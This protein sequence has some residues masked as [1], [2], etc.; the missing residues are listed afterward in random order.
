MSRSLFLL[1]VYLDRLESFPFP[2]WPSSWPTYDVVFTD[3]QHCIRR[4]M[5]WLGRTALS[6]HSRLLL[7]SYSQFSPHRLA[8]CCSDPQSDHWI[9]CTPKTTIASCNPKRWE[10][11][12]LRVTE[13]TPPDYIA[14]LFRW[15]IKCLQ[16]RNFKMLLF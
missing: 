13:E 7:T 9:G 4:Q 6:S 1:N 14:Q 2:M 8:C 16:R 10:F 15:Q 11:V 5:K 3:S 12:Y